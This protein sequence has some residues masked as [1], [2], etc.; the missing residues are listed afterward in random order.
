MAETFTLNVVY[1]NK[2]KEY[3]AELRMNGYVHNIIIIVDEQ[4]IIFEPDEERNYRAVITGNPGKQNPPDVELL[5][6]IANEI[7]LAFK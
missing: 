1:K 3:D 5:Q 2:A 4:E 6:A 7:E